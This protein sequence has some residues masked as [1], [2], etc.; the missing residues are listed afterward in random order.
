MLIKYPVLQ[1]CRNAKCH[2]LVSHVHFL[3]HRHNARCVLR[4]F[5]CQ[6]FTSLCFAYL[7]LDT[8]SAAI[9]PAALYPSF[10][11]NPAL[12]TKYA[13]KPI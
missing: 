1:S 9:F 6:C 10:A 12:I 2:A 5:R 7:L 3:C 11:V 8:S 4:L 13:L